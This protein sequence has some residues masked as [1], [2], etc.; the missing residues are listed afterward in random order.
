MSFRTETIGDAT[1]ILGD[2]REVLPTLGRVD[3][4]VTSPPY[5]QQRAYER[6]IAD[7]D[8]LV[9]PAL[10]AI[11]DAGQVFVNLGLI[12]R[13]GEVVEYW[14]TL[15]DAM[16]SADWRFF[17]WYV[18]DQGPGMPGDW[19]GRLAPAHEWVFHFN[20]EPRKPNKTIPTSYAG[21]VR[22]TAQTG[23]RLNDGSMS[24]WSHGLA[25]TQDT[26]IP[27]S[28]VRVMR[29]KHTGGIE[30][31]HPA[32]Y[33]VKLPAHFIDA[34]SDVGETICDPFMGSGT[35]GVACIKLGRK[36][37]GIEIEPKY[38]DIAC[39]RI[40]EAWKQPRLFEEPKPK[41]VQAELGLTS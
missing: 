8:A 26:K 10:S 29:H 25:A 14:R 11:P 9:P 22:S 7:W 40:E 21:Y 17:G 13:D 16:R 15:V 24:G 36:F 3:A 5:A 37:I 27:D 31:E 32:L 38:F 39:K 34:Y 28:V 2:C 19:Q 4:V 35:T 41:P 6:G 23:M 30:S 1:L 33:P 18:W 20:R 12:H